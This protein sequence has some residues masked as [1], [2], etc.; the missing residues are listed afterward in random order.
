MTSAS[1]LQEA[2]ETRGVWKAQRPWGHSQTF[3]IRP[4]LWNSPILKKKVESRKEA[5]KLEQR[6]LYSLGQLDEIPFK[7]LTSRYTFLLGC[8]RGSLEGSGIVTSKRV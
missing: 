7:K 6:E 3:P 2:S 5:Q 4:F 8:G 1:E